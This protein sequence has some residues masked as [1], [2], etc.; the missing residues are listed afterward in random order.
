MVILLWNILKE[1]L[2]TNQPKFVTMLMS[3]RISLKMMIT[4]IKEN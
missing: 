2:G 3:Y 4:L 1:H